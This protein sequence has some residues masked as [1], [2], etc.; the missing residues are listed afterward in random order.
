[1]D[2][3]LARG[4][5][6]V[7]SSGPVTMATALQ[8]GFVGKCPCC[9]R[10][11]LFERFLQVARQC[12]V[13]GEPFH[14][15]RADDLPAYL[16]LLFVGHLI[17]TLLVAVDAAYAPPYWVEFAIWIPLTL[18]L[19]LGLLQPVKGAVVAMQWQMGMHGFAKAKSERERD[20]GRAAEPTVPD[21]IARERR[22][23]HASGG[24]SVFGWEPAP[25]AFPLEIK[26]KPALN[27]G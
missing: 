11:R 23:S 8:R 1:M 17:V 22:L 14:H 12:D 15:H 18:L 9:G 21:A 20:L 3:V 26:P 7:S 27:R 10:G 25:E 6:Q 4:E 19:S 16:V 24:H 5:T 13:C 2:V